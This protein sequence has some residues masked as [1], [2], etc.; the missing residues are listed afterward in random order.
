MA[1]VTVTRVVDVKAQ[2]AWSAIRSIG[3]LDR[4]FQLIAKCDVQ[5]QGVGAKRVC[6]LANG[7]TLIER[8]EQIDD[9]AK[10]FKYSITDSPLPISDYL[11]TVTVRETGPS[12]AEIIWSARFDI[13]DEHRQEIVGTLNDAFADGIQGLERELKGRR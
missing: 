8:V 10:V 13:P 9:A 3:G 5:G 1:E 7:V 6:E 12:R 11:G 4:W 2:D